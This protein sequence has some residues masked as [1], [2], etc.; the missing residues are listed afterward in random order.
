MKA[1]LISNI[2][3]KEERKDSYIWQ[4]KGEI[5]STQSEGDP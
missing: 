1:T 4:G 2:K 5:P 3:A